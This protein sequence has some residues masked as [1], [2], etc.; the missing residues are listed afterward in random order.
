VSGEEQL[1]VTFP[2]THQALRAE[3]VARAAAF[4]VAMVP[5]PRHISSDCNMGMQAALGDESALRRLLASEKVD[6]AFAHWAGD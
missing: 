3:R 2:S 4:E 6:C 5:V 1:I